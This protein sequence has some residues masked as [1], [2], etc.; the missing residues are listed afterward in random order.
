MV[1]W[2]EDAAVFALADLL[3]LKAIVHTSINFLNTQGFELQPVWIW[4]CYSHRC[5]TV[6]IFPS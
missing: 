5:T 2:L 6:L 3:H 4:R 1:Q